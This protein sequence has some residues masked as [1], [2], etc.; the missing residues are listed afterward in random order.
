MLNRFRYVPVDL[1]PDKVTLHLY[2]TINGSPRANVTGPRGPAAVG[3]LHTDAEISS[4]RPLSEAFAIAIRMAN[5][6]DISIV[7]TGDATLW[8]G[9]WG[10][11]D[12]EPAVAV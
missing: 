7:V 1:H 10:D 9:A 12:A 3:G 11:L 5:R 2:R 4:S 6:A 8:D